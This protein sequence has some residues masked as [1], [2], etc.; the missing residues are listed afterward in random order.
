MWS[1][2]YECQQCKHILN[3]QR[4][5]KAWPRSTFGSAVFSQVLLQGVLHSM[6]HFAQKEPQLRS[7]L[8]FCT[9]SGGVLMIS[10]SAVQTID[11]CLLRLL[12]GKF[13][14]HKDRVHNE[15]KSSGTSIFSLIIHFTG[16]LSGIFLD[17]LLIPGPVFTAWR[18]N[19]KSK[20]KSKILNVSC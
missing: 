1:K 19:D 3:R 20:I 6:H 2:L 7:D 16:T 12:N 14:Q 17:T 13:R 9:H 5:H 18:I 4:E 15:Q 8:G 10:L 11:P